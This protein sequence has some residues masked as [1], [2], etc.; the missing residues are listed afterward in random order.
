LLSAGPINGY[1]RGRRAYRHSMADAPQPTQ[2]DPENAATRAAIAQRQQAE[3]TAGLKRALSKFG[4][5][6][7]P[8]GRHFLL[9]KGE[10]ERPR[11][12]GTRAVPA[13]TV[14][15]VRHEE[16]DEK[17]Y[18]TTEAG[19]VVEHAGYKE[20]FGGGLLRAH[21]GAASVGQLTCALGQPKRLARP[22]SSSRASVSS[23]PSQ[24]SLRPSRPDPQ[25][26]SAAE[27]STSSAAPVVTSLSAKSPCWEN[28]ART[29]RL[30]T[31]SF[32]ST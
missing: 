27:S 8:S 12:E 11:R 1:A 21:H 13:A 17:R 7:L 22:A 20:A 4:P 2:Q 3:N 32:T 23:R 10:E 28:L 15:C 16:T 31:A 18:F 24:F 14:Y 30:L 5:G 19:H 29:A 25:N 9:E 26:V 6:W